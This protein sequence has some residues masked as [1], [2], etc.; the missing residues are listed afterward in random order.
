M[1]AH[2]GYDKR[3]ANDPYAQLIGLVLQ[4][5]IDTTMTQSMNNRLFRRN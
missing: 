1:E 3:V 2:T 4:G 5:W